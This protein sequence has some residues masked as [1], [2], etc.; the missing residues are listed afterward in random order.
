MSTC[1]RHT[2][3]AQLIWPRRCCRINDNIFLRDSKNNRFTKIGTK[4]HS[5]THVR[6]SLCCHS[7]RCFVCCDATIAISSN[8]SLYHTLKPYT[9][10]APIYQFAWLLNPS[11]ESVFCGKMRLAEDSIA[12]RNK[13]HDR[14]HKWYTQRRPCIQRCHC[15]WECILFVSVV[16]ALLSWIRSF[17]R[18]AEKVLWLTSPDCLCNGGLNWQRTEPAILKRS[19]S[20]LLIFDGCYGAH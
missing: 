5:H 3:T 4:T 18:M 14:Y 16:V 15:L 2:C 20:L 19:L 8:H 9:P 11:I 7:N 13:N 12:T 6:W 10:F 1:G 17:I